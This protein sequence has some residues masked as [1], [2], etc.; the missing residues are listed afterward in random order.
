MSSLRASVSFNEVVVKL[1]GGKFEVFYA[2]EKKKKSCLPVGTK[3][4]WNDFSLH[5]DVRLGREI[6]IEG[7]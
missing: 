7:L 6:H 1:F 4:R 3:S 2:K 5:H